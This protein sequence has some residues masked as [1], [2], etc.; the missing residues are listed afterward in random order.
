MIQ[1]ASIIELTHWP[2]AVLDEQ[3]LDRMA[4]LLA[5]ISKRDALEREQ[6]RKRS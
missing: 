5:V 3:P 2:F 6:R 4:G 1:E